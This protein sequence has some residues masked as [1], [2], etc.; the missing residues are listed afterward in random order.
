M[1]VLTGEVININN[2]YKTYREYK[3]AVDTELQKSAESFVR[4]GYLLKVARDTDILQ[5]SGY[6]SVNDFAQ[7]EYNLDKSQVSRFIR[8]NDEYSE[9]GYSDHLQDRYR[10]FGYAKLALMLMLPS[11]IN[12][13]LSA[14]FSKTEIQSIKDEVEAEEKISDLEVWM[15]GKDYKQVEMGVFEK[16]LHQL[17]QDDPE[18]YLKLWD[19]VGTTIYD[20]TNRPVVDKLLNALAPAGEAVISVR[21]QGEGRKLLSIKGADF[22]PTIIDIRTQEKESCSWDEF[23]ESMENLCE[24]ENGKEG[25]EK[26][27]GER[28]PIKE[29][30]KKEEVAPVQPKEEKKKPSKVTKAKIEKLEPDKGMEEE[31]VQ[32]DCAEE[33]Q[34]GSSPEEELPGQMQLEK[35]FPEYCPEEKEEASPVQP[36]MP[37]DR[38]NTEHRELLREMKFRSEQVVINA[39]KREYGVSRKFLQRMMEILD[40]LEEDHGKEETT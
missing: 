2:E 21:I 8:I 16:V 5:E 24:G 36:E 32:E 23:I 12:E 9:N 20:G 35:D 1:D 18:L 33:E 39:E 31:P 7:A 10:G 6:A 29:A 22:N 26:V 19:A 40:K 27:Y 37:P 28:F 17:G 15:E 34:P 13:E 14:G 30:P 11:V 4:I 38:V 25:W 3:A